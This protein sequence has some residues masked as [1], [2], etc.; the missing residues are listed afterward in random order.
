MKK[1]TEDTEKKV[2]F[3]D[4][5]T[6]Y[7]VGH[8]IP[9][10]VTVERCAGIMNANY[11]AIVDK[12]CPVSI[13]TE[14]W[15]HLFHNSKELHFGR[16]VQFAKEKLFH[17]TILEIINQ[18]RL[19]FGMAAQLRLLV[20]SLEKKATSIV[21]YLDSAN[22]LQIA[23]VWLSV[24]SSSKIKNKTIIWM[25]FHRNGGW[26]ETKVGRA[27]R[28]IFEIVS[29]RT[30]KTAFT[31][32]IAAEN[33]RKYKWHVEILPLP[34]N[35]LVILPVKTQNPERLTCWLLVKRPDQGMGLIQK[36]VRHKSINDLPKKFIKCFIS[37]KMH[38]EESDSM[39]L[40]RL[41]IETKDY[42]LHFNECDVVLLPYEANLF[43]KGMSMVFVEA[44]A[45]SKIPIVSDETVMAKELRGHKLDKLVLDFNEEFSWTLVNEIR[46]STRIR[47]R[48]K[49]MAERYVI[50]HDTVA[51]AESLYKMLMEIIP[52]IALAQPK[53]HRNKNEIFEM[54]HE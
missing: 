33:R 23:A 42:Y 43:G 3:V 39:E 54:G 31:D 21:V 9:V 45:S 4:V 18:I 29:I 50:Q 1:P 44:V 7:G 35:P 8:Y 48:L 2:W 5:V 40:V 12:E 14:K 36:M 32:E 17:R 30:L 13:G 37:A 26:Q 52:T 47:E 19:F 16:A 22:A 25:H 41:P 46:E 11:I 34:L 28:Y 38:I 53:R 27:V 10:H 6:E 20:R 51:Y 15:L 49:L 24:A